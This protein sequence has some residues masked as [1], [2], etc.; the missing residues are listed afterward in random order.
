MAEFLRVVA[1]IAGVAAVLGLIGVALIY[2]RLKRL[3]IPEQATFRETLQRVPFS[4]VL[5]L[6]LLDLGFDF[7][8]APLVWVLLGRFNLG[9]LRR[10]SVVEALIP[11][12]QFIPTLTASWLAVRWF[13]PAMRSF[14]ASDSE[15]RR[16]GDRE[17]L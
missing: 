13:D 4:V 2:R 1:I 7:L 3:N 10:V 16:P 17:V 6:D 8:A 15:P 14:D 5:V 9:A 12:T 11:G